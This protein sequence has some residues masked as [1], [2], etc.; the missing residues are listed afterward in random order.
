MRYDEGLHPRSVQ[1]T[2][3]LLAVGMAVAC[4][5]SLEGP[6]EL[7]DVQG[8]WAYSESITEA[9][10]AVTCDRAGTL[11][12]EQQELVLTGTFVRTGSCS[13]A[14]AA[15]SAPGTESGAIERGRAIRD[16]VEFVIGA[17][18]YQGTIEPRDGRPRV[19]GSVLCHG[20]DASSTGGPL[21]RTGS[22]L[23]TRIDEPGS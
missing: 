23:A 11:A 19:L 4:G 17:C 7:P 5:G 14:A 1:G 13:G 2:P 8:S 10:S 6:A 22:W 9:S 12:L 3:L 16:R 20:P 18:Q 15:A 21:T